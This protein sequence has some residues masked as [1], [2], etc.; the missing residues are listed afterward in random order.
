MLY[1]ARSKIVSSVL[2]RLAGPVLASGQSHDHAAQGLHLLISE[3][4]AVNGAANGAHHG[5]ALL[6]REEKSAFLQFAFQVVE[7]VE[8]F[9]ARG[10]ALVWPVLETH[11]RRGIA[12]A[13]PFIRGQQHR[14]S[15]VYGS[16]MRGGNGYDAIAQR[17]FIVIEAGA[18][19]A[20]ENGAFLA[21]RGCDPQAA[22]RFRGG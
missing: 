15:Q 12:G 14:L 4:G 2:Y 21:T 5:V 22:R 3:A 20:K 9:G 7:Q 1:K 18:L 8:Q 13:K 10:P 19:V 6:G 17:D 11:R 16:E